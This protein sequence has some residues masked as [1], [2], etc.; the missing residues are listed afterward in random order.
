MTSE[1]AVDGITPF[2][3]AAFAEARERYKK[4]PQERNESINNLQAMA[5]IAGAEWAAAEVP[6]GTDEGGT[7]PTEAQ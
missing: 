3:L 2:Y 1:R 5:F 4:N 7:R 6:S